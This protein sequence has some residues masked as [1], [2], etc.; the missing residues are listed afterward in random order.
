MCTIYL[1][2]R[3]HESTYSISKYSYYLCLHFLLFLQ[4]NYEFAKTN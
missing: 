3:R 1:L 2:Y 4:Q